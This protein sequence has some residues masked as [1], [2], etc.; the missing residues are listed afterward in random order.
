MLFAATVL[1]LGTDDAGEL[2]LGLVLCAVLVVV[3]LTDLDLRMIPNKVVLA[4]AIAAIAIAALSDPDSLAERAI[5]A[6][7]AGGVLSSSRSPTRGG[8]GWAT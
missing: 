1:I 4:G 6:A 5:A 7:A 8:W 3:T 2:A